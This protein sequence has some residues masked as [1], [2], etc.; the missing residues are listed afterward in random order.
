MTDP[1]TAEMDAVEE[2]LEQHVGEAASIT[3]GEISEK[4]G[5]MDT[6][7][8]TPNTRAVIRAL[9]H[10]RGLPVVADTDGYYLV[11]TEEE[12]TAYMDNLIQ[13]EKRIAERR[14]AVMAAA[15]ASGRVSPTD[16]G[17]AQS[18]LADHAGERSGSSTP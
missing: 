5:G 16:E 10:R 9:V 14:T 4:V 12:L 1:S 7:D 2:V 13:R 6:L 11:N 8:S 3:S 15:Y 18:S 17:E